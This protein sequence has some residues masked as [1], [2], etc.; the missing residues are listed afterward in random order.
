MSWQACRAK[1][2]SNLREFK[3]DW[4][5]MFANARKFNGDN[6]WVVDNARALQKELE[7]LLIKNGFSDNHVP[8]SKKKKLRIKLSLKDLK[9]KS[10]SA[11]D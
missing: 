9:A 11:D 8:T 4:T 1:L 5:L 2:Y 7:R 3:A 10:D 6:S